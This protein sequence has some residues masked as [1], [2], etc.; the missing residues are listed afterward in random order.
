[1]HLFVVPLWQPSPFASDMFRNFLGF[2]YCGSLF[3]AYDDCPF[4]VPPALSILP[5]SNGLKGAENVGQGFKDA[6]VQKSP[7]KVLDLR[8]CRIFSKSEIYY[9][10]SNEKG[11]SC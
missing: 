7:S 4:F 8:T 10:K 11:V 2:R 3:S 6:L 1:M 9:I 5:R